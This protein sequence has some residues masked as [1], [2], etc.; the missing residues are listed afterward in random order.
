MKF[1][2]FLKRFCAFVLGAVFLI[3]GLFKLMDPVG[4]GLV[5]E[6]YLNFLHLGFLRGGA[7]VFALGFNLLECFVGIALISGIWV[8]IVRLITLVLL[9][10]FTFLT[11]LLLIFN[12]EMDCGCFGEIVHLTHLQSFLKNIILLLLWAF[13]FLPF[14]KQ[15]PRPLYRKIV[16]GVAY[17]MVFGFAIYSLKNMPILDLTDLRTGTELDEGKLSLL[18]ESG[19]Y[20]DDILLHGRT[21]VISVYNPSHAKSSVISSIRHLASKSRVKT[22]LAVSGELPFESR[23]KYSADRKSLLSLNRANMGV[24]FVSGGQI[25]Q[26]W[27][28][29]EFLAM[30]SEDLSQILQT[31]PTELVID[32]VVAGRRIFEIFSMALIVILLV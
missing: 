5:M 28:P 3:G 32:E 1:F 4:S 8:K 21:L 11:A 14:L 29:S 17:F 30:S 15:H 18:D 31:D 19:T 27:T 2:N 22:V 24:T 12:P 16:S 23:D 9:L 10:F 20:A 25:S 26:K 6:S 7:L 13:A